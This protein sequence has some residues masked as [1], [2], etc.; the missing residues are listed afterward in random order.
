MAASR[1][2]SSLLLLALVAASS[3][4][5]DPPSR[6][7]NEE[8]KA[9][10]EA[11]AVTAA[12]AAADQSKF[13]AV[14]KVVHLLETL[15]GDVEKEGEEEAATY[16]TFACFCKDAQAEKTAAITTGKD[17]SSALSSTIEALNGERA[18]LDTQ[19]AEL[20]A[21][22]EEA[23]KA[24]AV[25]SEK[26]GAE[27]KEYEKN[28]ADLTAAF[29]ALGNAI[30]VLKASKPASLAQ[31]QSVSNTVRTAALLA[32]ALG[33]GS[34]QAQ[35]ALSSFL[36]QA[37]DVPMQNYNFHSNG[38]VETLEQLLGDFKRQKIEV[39]KTEV[40]A[41]ISHELFIQEK[42]DIIKTKNL[43]LDDAKQ[44][45]SQKQEQVASN[46]QRLT[47]VEA[48]LLDDEQYLQEVS[49]M[50]ADKA[51]TWDQRSRVRQDELSALTAAIGIVKSTVAEKTSAST[52]R[53]TQQGVSLKIVEAL[54]TNKGAMEALEADAEA[55]DA[56]A[57]APSLLQK[58][59]IRRRTVAPAASDPDARQVI[60]S[61][62]RTEGQELKSA[63]LTALAVQI[64]AD[65]LAKV[66]TL[67]QE[68]IERLLKEAENE[69]NQKG[70]CDKS[71]SEAEQKRDYAADAVTR[72]NG[73]MARLEAARDKLSEELTLLTSE[74]A[75]LEAKQAEADTLRAAEKAQNNVTVSEAK[76]GLEAVKEA[77]DVLQ[78][79][80]KTAAKE[81][82][83]LA[84]TQ[85]A[86]RKRQPSIDAPDA[87]FDNGEAYTGSQGAGGGIVGML[88]VIQGDFERTISTTE[89][90]EAQAEQDYLEF[91][92]ETGKSHAEKSAAKDEKTRQKDST[93]ESLESAE[94]G[95][96]AQSE[97]LNSAIE[98]VLALQPP[99]I[100]TGQSYEERVARRRDE[101]EALKKAVCVLDN[102]SQYGPEGAAG[103]C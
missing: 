14:D 47:T 69:N 29:E 38:I 79:F 26:R 7:T 77:I 58:V 93:E 103:A 3:A 28:S 91:S 56:A 62:L 52:V 95:L 60:A 102:F 99:C 78:K 68:L 54:A 21:T 41:S 27:V 81:A 97:I 39:D 100:N 8:W 43:E 2:L 40:S 12:G 74:I 22:I 49:R 57:S 16:N 37:P 18:A 70:W 11:E 89:A 30:Q 5:G 6:P 42:T 82:V 85:R 50:C 61:L 101:I 87:G 71:I 19:I 75:D 66:K 15:Q 51:K 67:I 46:S 17:A 20:V 76:E 72:L 94:Q 4:Q 53:L 98:E 90:A 35:A 34:A 63:A 83:Q 9:S 36:Q 73:D 32:D 84:L 96:S 33:L 55:V 23:E 13:S 88:E 48:T 24:A 10:K 44:L 31:L 86:W 25:A 59:L 45:K 80:Y 65:P 92:T 1:G 64:S